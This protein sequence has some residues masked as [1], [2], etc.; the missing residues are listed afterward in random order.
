MMLCLTS[1]VLDR[2][3]S[4]LEGKLSGIVDGINPYWKLNLMFKCCR[5]HVQLPTETRR[6]HSNVLD[7][8]RRA[9]V[10]LSLLVPQHSKPNNYKR[11]HSDSST[12]DGRPILC[13]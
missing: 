12:A 4:V 11:Y 7:Q 5:V 9:L 3:A 10:D 2:D 1:A 6:L 8:V 13:I